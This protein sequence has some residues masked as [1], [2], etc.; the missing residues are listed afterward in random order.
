MLNIVCTI[1]AFRRPD[2]LKQCLESITTA[3]DWDKYPYIISIDNH[4]ATKNEMI[5][6][7]KEFKNKGANVKLYYQKSNLGCAGN[8]YF[9]LDKAFDEYKA[10]AIVHI[11]ED[12]IIAKDCLRWL[13]WAIENTYND[14]NIF[15]ACSFIRTA[16]IPSYKPV[17]ENNFEKSFYR[18]H[19]ECGSLW[20]MSNKIYSYIKSIN[21]CFGA[22]G[23]TNTDL[24]PDEWRKSISETFK[25]SWAWNFNKFCRRQRYCIA[26][27]YSRSNNIGAERAVF[28][29]SKKWHQENVWNDNWIGNDEYK[30]KDLSNI[31]YILPTTEVI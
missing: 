25:G 24:P 20:G 21:G 3:Y 16:Q 30:D 1:K 28:N 9:I 4:E 12:N 19:Y 10:D 22:V 26:P 15:A 17:L 8:T 14:D 23:N 31:K 7:V 6:C 5:K 2:Y 29:P 13:V 11:E 27:V 18:N